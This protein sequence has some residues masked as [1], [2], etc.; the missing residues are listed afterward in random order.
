VPPITLNNGTGKGAHEEFL[1]RVSVH[2]TLGT[3]SVYRCTFGPGL[4]GWHEARKK[5]TAQARHVTKLFRAG[6]ARPGPM[7]RAVLGQTLRPTG[8]HEPDPFKQTRNGP[9]TGTKRPEMAASTASAAAGRQRTC[10]RRM[11][12]RRG[13]FPRN[14]KMSSPLAPVPCGRV[15]SPS[16]HRLS[17]PGGQEAPSSSATGAAPAR[18]RPCVLA[19]ARRSPEPPLRPCSA[20]SPLLDR[21]A[22][23][24][25]LGERDWSRP[26]SAARLHPYTA[27]AL[28][29]CPHELQRETARVRDAPCAAC[30][31]RLRPSC[32][33]L[34]YQM[35]ISSQICISGLYYFR[36]ARL[37]PNTFS[38]IRGGPWAKGSARGPARHDPNLILGRA[39]PKLNVPGLFGLG[40]GRTGRPECTPIAPSPSPSPGAVTATFFAECP[41]KKYSTQKTLFLQHF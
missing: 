16:S 6:P 12:L 33:L 40:P 32:C 18:L 5:S 7:H 31:L 36:T 23:A 24:P 38:Y 22:S 19:R 29:A 17:L 1:C 21:A 30:V 9:L 3:D 37:K 10:P 28:P 26:C 27:C 39:G 20:E 34:V 14:P 4:M 11:G 13:P 35:C 8:G 15:P 2:R 25:L 41:I